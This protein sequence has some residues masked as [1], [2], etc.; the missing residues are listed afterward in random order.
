MY[1]RYARA[2][3]VLRHPQHMYVVAP[4][5]ELRPGDEAPLEPFG[6]LVAFSW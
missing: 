2:S 4:W 1:T 3:D 6:D 5:P